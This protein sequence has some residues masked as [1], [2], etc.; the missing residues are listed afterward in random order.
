MIYH[1]KH[2][3][4]N[5]EK[6]DKLAKTQAIPYALSWYLNIVSPN[7]EALIFDDYKAIMPLTCKKKFGIKYLAQP[8]FTQQSG[9]FGDDLNPQLIEKFLT[10]IDKCYHYIEINLNES[11]T[12]FLN[13]NNHKT[14]SLKNILLNLSKPYDLLY[15]S[16]SENTKRMIKKA[17]KNSIYICDEKESDDLI[18]LFKI[19]KGKTLKHLNSKSYQILRT[20]IKSAQE[21]IDVKVKKVYKDR[22]LLG[23]AVF[24]EFNDRIIFFFSALDEKG[25][26]VGAMHYLISEIIKN[27]SGKK[28]LLDFE[29][30]NNVNLARFYMSFGSKEVVYLRYKN[31]NLPYPFKWIKN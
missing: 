30:S 14:T 10:I 7:W 3:E 24:F 25:K 18:E 17:E 27:N 29:G 28:K 2:H 13:E 19:T 20:L 4:I 5:F 6:W 11:N 26:Q 12:L 21:N 16:F 8:F 23:G 15:K 22:E 31:N 1:L 9:I